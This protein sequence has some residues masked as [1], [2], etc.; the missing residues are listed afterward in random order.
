MTLDQFHTAIAEA[1]LAGDEYIEAP[2]EI[3][4]KHN[5]K[6]LNG[7]AFFIYKGIKVYPEG[8][9]LELEKKQNADLLVT[10]HGGVMAKM[11][12]R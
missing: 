12:G 3:I 2:L 10:L 9:A 4:L 6:G 1:Q 5:K 8:Q 11:E 7:S